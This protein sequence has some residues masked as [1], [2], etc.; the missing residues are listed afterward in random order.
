MR[1]AWSKYLLPFPEAYYKIIQSNDELKLLGSANT[2]D[3]VLGN[4]LAAV[5]RRSQPEAL[6]YRQWPKS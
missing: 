2:A 4:H 5:L 6:S 3:A 1:T